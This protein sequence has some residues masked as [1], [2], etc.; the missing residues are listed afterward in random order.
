MAD[1]TKVIKRG[2]YAKKVY[3]PVEKIK[4]ETVYNPSIKYYE[5]T[6]SRWRWF[7]WEKYPKLP[8]PPPTATQ[9]ATHNVIIMAPVR[10]EMQAQNIMNI[11][12][13]DGINAI[14]QKQTVD[15]GFSS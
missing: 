15:K 5:H 6:I 14:S 2:V 7:G 13:V 8:Q 12:L 9:S 3:K 1:L 10:M 11:P 4:K